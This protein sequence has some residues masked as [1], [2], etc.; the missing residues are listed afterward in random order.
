MANIKTINGTRDLLP[1]YT[2]SAHFTKPCPSIIVEESQQ[3]MCKWICSFLIGMIIIR[4]TFGSDLPPNSLCDLVLSVT[5]V[6]EIYWL[7]ECHPILQEYA[8]SPSINA[9]QV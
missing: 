8:G 7:L 1:V 3:I 9:V 5:T 6:M 4:L 2:I